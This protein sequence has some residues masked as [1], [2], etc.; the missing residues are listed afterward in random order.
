MRRFNLLA[1]LAALLLGACSTDTPFATPMVTGPT[2]S[3][4]LGARWF[5]YRHTLACTRELTATEK[6]AMTADKWQQLRA[7]QNTST[8]RSAPPPF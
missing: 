5:C 7:V 8:K 4:P 1:L 2:V 3:T 6:V